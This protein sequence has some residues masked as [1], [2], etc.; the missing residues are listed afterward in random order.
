[1]PELTL[2][3]VFVEFMPDEIEPGKLY[4]SMEYATVVHA[5]CCGCGNQVVTP[6]SPQRWKLMFD[7]KSITLDPSIGNWSFPCKSHYFIRQSRVQ[8]SRTWTK[9]EIAWVQANDQQALETYLE[10]ETL[11]S[12]DSGTIQSVQIENRP[13]KFTFW[14][15]IAS[16]FGYRP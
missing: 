2:T 16:W 6:L 5:C 14:Q 3:P 15:R 1:M 13:L 11:T 4:V 10:P 8:W 9:R 7:G 12:E